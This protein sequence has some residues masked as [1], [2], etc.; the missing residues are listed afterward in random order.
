[1]SSS[2]KT[3]AYELLFD[4]LLSIHCIYNNDLS[5]LGDFNIP[6]YLDCKNNIINPTTINSL[7]PNFCNIFELSQFNNII[8]HHGRLL[9]LDS[10]NRECVVNAAPEKILPE[11]PYHT[12]LLVELDIEKSPNEN[13]PLRQI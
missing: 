2:C 9:Y 7:T 3:E 1:M 13:F 12:A 11:D 4:T 6:E 5:I 8:N 10:N